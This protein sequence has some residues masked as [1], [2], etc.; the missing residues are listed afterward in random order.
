MFRI[1]RAYQPPAPDDGVRILVDRLW[2]RGL[3]KEAAAI[4]TWLKDIAPSAELRKWFGHDPQRWP[5]FQERYREELK[6][7]ERLAALERLRAARQESG[8]VTLLFGAREETHNHAAFL[9][10]L[11]NDE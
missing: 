11:L 4:D 5:R 1:K 8:V 7:P 9:R 6:A 10:D 3:T 2:R